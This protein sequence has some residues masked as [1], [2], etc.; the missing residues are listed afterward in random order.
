MNLVLTSM[1]GK[2]SGEQD[3]LLNHFRRANE[4]LRNIRL[5]CCGGQYILPTLSQKFWDETVDLLTAQNV[6]DKLMDK[7]LSFLS[8]VTTGQLSVCAMCGVKLQT[9]L[10]MPCV[11]LICTECVEV[12]AYV[13]GLREV[14]TAVCEQTLV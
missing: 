11:C 4:V 8:R 5:S 9:L 7:G 14:D 10:L 12:S 1:E 3:S 6:D 13:A 2:T